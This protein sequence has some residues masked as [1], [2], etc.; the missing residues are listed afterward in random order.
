VGAARACVADF[1]SRIG[2]PGPVLDGIRLAVS[3]AVSNVVL[4]GYR[5]G[6]TGPFTVVVE[7]EGGELVVSV[8]DEGA[9]LTPRSDS[10]G[11]GLG[12]PLIAELTE[13]LSVT[14]GDD[15]RGTV[16]RMTFDLPFAGAG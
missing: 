3:E 10:P 6:P 16:L 5:G 2:A 11:A 15:G 7:T 1:A 9:G 14:P 12:L 4:H 13:S 8:Q